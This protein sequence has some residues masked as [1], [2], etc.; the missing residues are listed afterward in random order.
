MDSSNF[1]LLASAFMI[2]TTV[3]MTF[4]QWQYVPSPK[5]VP[6]FA[7]RFDIFCRGSDCGVALPPD[8]LIVPQ[9]KDAPAY[10]TDS[11]TS[12]SRTTLDT[13][14]PR[15]WVGRSGEAGMVRLRI[16]DGGALSVTET[17]T[18]APGSAVLPTGTGQCSP[19]T[20]TSREQG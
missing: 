12:D 6:H 10:L 17:A 18:F 20:A 16:S 13:V 1:V 14:T 9:A 5:A 11:L 7:C 19:M 3:M 8:V 15:E 4:S 2:V